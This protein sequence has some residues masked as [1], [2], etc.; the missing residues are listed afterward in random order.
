[1]ELWADLTRVFDIETNGFLRELDRIHCLWIADPAAGTH[2]DYADQ[3]GYRPIE[4]GIKRLEEADELIGHNIIKFDLPAIKKVHPAFTPKA[5]RIRDSMVLARMIWPE[6]KKT[7]AAKRQSNRDSMPGK[8]VGKYSLAAFGYRL[9]ILKGEYDGSWETWNQEMH[10]YCGQDVRVNSALWEKALIKLQAYSEESIE[11]E[12]DFQRVI[13]RQEDWGWRFNEQEAAKLYATLA[14]KRDELE[15]QL[16]SVFQPWYGRD[17]GLKV[18][19]FTPKKDNK[20]MGYW[21]GATLT[22]VKLTEFNPKSTQHIASRLIAVRGWKPAEFTPEGHP[23]VDD[24]IISKLPY[25]EAPLIGEYLMVQKRIG[26]LAEGKEAWLKRVK[27]GRIH[28]GV[29][30]CGTITRRCA[31]I[32]PNIAQAVKVGKP[33]GFEFRSLFMA[34]AGFILVGCDADSLELRMLGGYMAPYDGGAYIDVILKGNKANG[35][36]MHCV[37]AKAIGLDPAKLYPVDG[38]ELSGREIAKVWFYAM[39]YGA[40]PENL[41]WIMGK[42]GDP[43]NPAHFGTSTSAPASCIDLYAK[44]YGAKSKADFCEE[45]A[46]PRQLLEKVGEKVKRTRL[47]QEHRRRTPADPQ[48]T[49]RT[50]LTA[51]VCWGDLHEEGVCDP[52]RTAPGRGLHPRRRLRVRRQHP[53]R[54]ANRR[55]P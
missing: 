15:A 34:S 36:D 50:Q 32:A 6:L 51:P 10:D 21:A 44:K 49:R 38:I 22:K 3:P 55:T 26:Q 7:D 47:P 12:M 39:I 40:G 9:G 33:Y 5:K 19:T 20:K 24:G 14:T 52:G 27:A 30:T 41:G 17:G 8:L 29:L 42:R 48:R 37:N 4:E 53:R 2:D 1:L 43:D 25:P 46:G 28:G 11:L 54:V 31:H 45:P 23:K 35:T 16:K 13:A 18:S